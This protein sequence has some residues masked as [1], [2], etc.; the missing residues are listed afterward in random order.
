MSI[1]GENCARCTYSNRKLNW[2]D[3]MTFRSKPGKFIGK[4]VVSTVDTPEGD[5]NTVCLFVALN[6]R[7]ELLKEIEIL[8]SLPR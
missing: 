3:C 8:W 5:S 1:I 4:F 6:N 2:F 7:V